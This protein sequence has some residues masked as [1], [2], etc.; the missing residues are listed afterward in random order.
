[1]SARLASVLGCL[2][3]L[4]LAACAVGTG[5]SPTASPSLRSPTP[6]IPPEPTTAPTGGFTLEV[7]P[8]EDPAAVRTAIPGEQVCFLVVVADAAGGAAP[9]AI[10]ATA[11]KATILR[12]LPAA[13]LAP[14]TVGEVWVVPDASSVE[15]TAS[16]TIRAERGGLTRTVERSLPIFPMVDERAA[17]AQPHFE[18][19]VAWLASAHSELGI[20]PTT[21]WEPEF[22]STLLVV[23]HY[24]YW[25]AD[26][27]LT[28]AWHIMIAPY[29]WS[30]IHLRHR[31]TE[32]K[33]S[34]AFRVDSVSGGTTPHAVEPP[35]V[36][37]R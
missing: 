14:G 4:T 25:S 24:A 26:W 36:V 7:I 12:I 16:V 5:P 6:S 31:W 18:R 3:V 34:L 32:T 20:T 8:P 29:D 9:V 2:C 21:D 27:E 35:E 10:S 13:E 19:W 1:M 30:E 28:V 37:V 23:S 17:D 11:S 33:P 15:T 22:V